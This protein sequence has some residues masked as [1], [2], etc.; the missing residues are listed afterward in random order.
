MNFP[1]DSRIVQVNSHDANNFEAAK[2]QLGYATLLPDDVL[3]LY[4]LQENLFDSARSPGPAQMASGLYTLCSKH[5]ILGTLALLRLHSGQACRET[6]AAVE[7]AGIAYVIQKNPE[8]YEIF[9]N[10]DGSDEA[11]RKRARN[12]FKTS[13]IFPAN[14]PLIHQLLPFY[15]EASHL[16][17]TNHMTFLQHVSSRKAGSQK[18]TFNYQ[19]IS[20]DSVQSMLPTMLF[21]LCLAHLFILQATNVVFKGLRKPDVDRFNK[22]CRLVCDRIRRFNQKQLQTE[23]GSDLLNGLRF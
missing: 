23:A 6:R 11:A 2:R 5:L 17:H 10:D 9:L 18:V 20:P 3:K 14:E 15:D 4:E 8:M 12:A 21:W 13:V 22:E 19:D 1:K 7:S 16:S